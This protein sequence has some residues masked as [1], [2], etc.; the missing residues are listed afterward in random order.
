MVMAG[1]WEPQSNPRTSLEGRFEEIG[2]L[3]RE[4]QVLV[5][6]L[7]A[8]LDLCRFHPLVERAHHDRPRRAGCQC[9]VPGGLVVRAVASFADAGRR[10]RRRVVAAWRDDGVPE[11][12]W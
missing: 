12:V 10:A 3:L 5:A 9:A 6:P 4:L 1:R 11:L 8:W 2:V 7:L